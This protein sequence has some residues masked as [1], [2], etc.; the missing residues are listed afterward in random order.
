ME[1][2]QKTHRGLDSGGRGEAPRAADRG[3]E[4]MAANPETENPSACD[5]LMEE[6]CEREN[7]KRALKRVKANKGAPGVD[8]ITVHALPGFLREHWLSIRATLLNRYP[9]EPGGK[10]G[11]R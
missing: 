2:Q 9:D 6:I 4:S 5:R 3:A 7:L 8:G 1:A 10:A 11:W